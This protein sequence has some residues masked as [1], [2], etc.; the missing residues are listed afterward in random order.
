M[1][2]IF[3]FVLFS[4]FFA[5]NSF[6]QFTTDEITYG[7]RIDLEN[8]N[9]W[10]VGGGF[11]NFIMHGDMRSLGTS[12][13]TNYWNF[14]LYGYV[15]KMFNPLLGLELKA[16]FTKISGGAQYFSNVY[17]LEYVPNTV[18][19]DNMRFEGKAYGAELN[20]IFSF[21]N[22]YQTTASKWHA[23]GYFGVGYHLYDS[24]LFEIVPGAAD[25]PLV[26]FGKNPARN[27]VN[28]ASSI[29][30]SAQ[31]GLKRRINKR[32][33]LEFRTGMYFNY[34]DHLDAAI[35]N[36]QDWETFF[37]SSIGVAV[38]L[39]KKKIFTIWGD[40][41]GKGDNFKIIDTDKDGVM[42]QLDIEPNTPAGVMV[43][44]NGKAVDSDKDGLP[45]YKDKCPLKYGPISNEGCPLNVDSDGDGI[46]DGEDLCPNTPGVVENRGCPKQEA[47]KP[48]NIN[49]QIGLLAASIYFDTNSDR[50]KSISFATIDKI[51]NLMKKV[52]NVKFVIEGHTD[53][54]NSDRYNLYLS[55]R[56]AA[57]VRKYMV[58]QGIPSDRLESKGYG[59][60]RP[61]FS[62]SNAGGR[63]LNRRVEIKPTGSIE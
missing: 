28:Q 54:R 21:T 57:S 53:D 32:V 36:K 55:Q 4:T 61:K 46:M 7:N 24:Q 30:L 1:R 8:S 35:S 2:R 50:I 9:S 33:D 43:Y 27:S 31:F 11:S 44:G 45:D 48:D 47:A 40:E 25:N 60:S 37:V 42:D 56:R 17:E 39:G 62:N 3:L 59:E 5:A 13:D 51:I 23:A 18:I 29:Y 19:R 14:G 58:K 63:Q 15:N 34:E 49:Q 52:P 10:A 26:D 6:S 41:G 20:L 12:D 22:L 16:S 38:K